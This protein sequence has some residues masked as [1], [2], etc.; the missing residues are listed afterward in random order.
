MTRRALLLDT[1][2]WYWL[3][4]GDERLG[5]RARSRVASAAKEQR[6]AVSAI[7]SY[8][9]S[10]KARKGKLE[11]RPDPDEW[12]RRAGSLPGISVM[13]VDRE[14]MSRAA[15]LPLQN[16]D[17]ADRMLIATALFYDLE[18]VT[19]DRLIL[20]FA[21]QNRALQVFHAAR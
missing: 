18:L 4:L 10:A 15:S 9:L 19:A 6:V 5:R 7:S 2:V 17:P 11:L 1:H 14:I 8:E 21:T 13:Q 16:A 12:L 3:V 20:D